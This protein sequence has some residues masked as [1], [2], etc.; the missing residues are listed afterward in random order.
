MKKTDPAV[1]Q[2]QLLARSTELRASVAQQSQGLKK[3]LAFA[4]K[5]REGLQWIYRNPVLPLGV[6]LV[7]AVA[8]PKRTMLIWGGRL[9]GAWTTYNSLRGVVAPRARQARTA[10]RR[11][12]TPR[13]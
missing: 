6:G 1:R 13:Q 2:Q 11:S 10:P 8:L 12:R 9:W 5:A 4:D 3:P 7:L